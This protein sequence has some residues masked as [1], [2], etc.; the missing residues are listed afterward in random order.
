MISRVGKA[1]RAHLGPFEVGTARRRA[2]A[3]PT[4]VRRGGHHAAHD[5]CPH[6]E[7]RVRAAGQLGIGMTCGHW[8]PS[9]LD[10]AM[11]AWVRLS[12]PSFWR[13]A[14][15]WALTVASDTLSS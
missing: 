12:T 15:T 7:E 14:E 13:M 9:I 10:A 8:P 6:K 1:K 4:V 11:T 2:F 3:H 5:P